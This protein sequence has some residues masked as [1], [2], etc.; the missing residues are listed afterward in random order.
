MRQAQEDK[1]GKMVEAGTPSDYNQRQM[2]NVH[3]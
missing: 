3:P 2:M 1:S